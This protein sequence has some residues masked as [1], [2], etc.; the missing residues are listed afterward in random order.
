MIM[1]NLR[2]QSHGRILFSNASETVAE[3]CRVVHNVSSNYF[4][5]LKQKHVGDDMTPSY[6]YEIEVSLFNQK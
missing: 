1:E 5:R 6:F 2:L 3:I 4:D